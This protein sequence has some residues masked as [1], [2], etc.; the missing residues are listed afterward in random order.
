MVETMAEL[1]ALGVEW[2]T[3]HPYARI[4][5]DGT[6]GF[7][8]VD[9]AAPPKHIARPIREAHALGLKMMIKPHLAYWGRKWDWRGAI[10][11]QGEDLVRFQRSYAR[12]IE[13]MA[14]ASKGAD[15][16][17]V[18]TELDRLT[19][20]EVWWRDIIKRV[21]SSY[22]GPLTFAS[23]WDSYERIAFW[24]A[25]DAVGI[26]AYFPLVPNAEAPVDDDALRA[27]WK[28]VMTKLSAYSKAA[29]RPIVFTELGYNVSSKAALEPWD[30]ERGG[31]D[32]EG[33]QTRCMEAA[34]DA[35]AAEPAVR[36]AFVW[37]WFSG[38][39]HA[40]DF[41]ASTPA[42]RAVLSRA[43]GEPT[44]PGAASPPHIR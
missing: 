16:F 28:R 18:G 10:D 43:W 40:E 1:Q 37:K 26:Q 31:P 19:G 15:L 6:V 14:V 9:P 38:P 17:V 24:D 4:E 20:H 22:S 21:R 44:K 2:I 5:N 13:A 29:Q 33:L 34:L 41:L 23:N 8:P 25:L 39:T 35:I 11:L 42:M 12:W 27:G 7:K 3:I 36:G 32:A 30:Y